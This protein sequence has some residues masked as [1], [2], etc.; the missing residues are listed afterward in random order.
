MK[1]TNLP[2]TNYSES[3]LHTI[4]YTLEVCMNNYTSIYI[5]Y[6]ASI[7]PDQSYCLAV[8]VSQFYFYDLQRLQFDHQVIFYQG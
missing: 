4:G 7:I 6:F 1:N 2:S 5:R 8:T 3:K